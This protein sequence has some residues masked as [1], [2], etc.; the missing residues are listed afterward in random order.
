MPLTNGGNKKTLDA[1]I[2]LV[3]VVVFTLNFHLNFW[4]VASP[5]WFQ[6][7]QRDSEALVVGRLI[8]TQHDSPFSQNRNLGWWG[9]D[10]I[11]NLFDYQY[12]LYKSGLHAGDFSQLRYIHYTSQMGLQ[13]FMLGIADKLL[14]VNNSH[15]LKLFQLLTSIALSAVF[16]VLILWFYKEFGV[17]AAIVAFVT[18]VMS[19]W[20]VVM[21]RNLYW[22]LWLMYLPLLEVLI[23]LYI[24]RKTGRYYKRILLILIFFLIFL[25]CGSG[26]EFISTIMISMVVPFVYYK[27][28][29]SWSMKEFL[30]RVVAVGCSA[31]AGFATTLIVHAWQI[32]AS[33]RSLLYG[34]E[35]IWLNVLK[36]THGNPELVPEVYHNSLRAPVFDVL[37]Y[38]FNVKVLASLTTK[39]LIFLFCLASILVFISHEYSASISRNRKKLIALVVTLW[40]SILAPLSWLILAKGHSY[41]HVH[42]NPVLWNIPFTILGFALTGS[43][44]YLLAS[45]LLKIKIVR[46]S[47][48]WG[49]L[50]SSLAAIF[51]IIGL[52][53]RSEIYM[54]NLLADTIQV[55]HNEQFGKVFISLNENKLIYLPDKRANVTDRFF[56][57][58]YPSDGPEVLSQDRQEHG[59]DNLDF[60]FEEKKR[61]IFAKRTMAVIDLPTYAIGSIA[62]GQFNDEKRLWEVHFRLNGESIERLMNQ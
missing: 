53:I 56:L 57:H 39:D 15:K 37:K 27:F 11:D 26:Y 18:T 4:S 17:A 52:S 46:K 55:E 10:E 43:V 54:K 41:I 44:L 5:E 32:S 59:F 45:D 58:V 24:E 9:S 33:S 7:Y 3:I 51:V 61:S 42:I 30:K 14:P 49:L 50:A 47:I 34:F 8:A 62:T 48:I 60:N 38:Y 29:N 13:G 12:E 23:F 6:S 2:F 16:T 31:V 35:Q 36:R 20:L 28:I 21:G 1:I 22:Q 19:Q 25:K 40:A